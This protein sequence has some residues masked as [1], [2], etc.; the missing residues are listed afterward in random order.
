MN[1]PDWDFDDLNPPPPPAPKGDAFFGLIVW[2]FII[3][4]ISSLAL[5]I[6]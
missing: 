5:W 2:A 4:G 3:W 1:D 6:F